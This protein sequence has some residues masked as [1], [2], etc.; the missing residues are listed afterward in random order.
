MA[1]NVSFDGNSLQTAN[2]LTQ[3]IDHASI[4][5][6]DAQMYAIAHANKSVIPFVAYPSKTIKLSGVVLDSSIT[7]LDSRLDTFRA[8][9]LNQDRNLDIDYNGVTRRYTATVNS[10]SINR[11]GGLLYATFEIE[12]VC[13]QPFGQDTSTSSILSASGRTSGSYTDPFT[14]PASQT[15]PWQKPV[16]T[17]TFTALTA[18]GS[19]NVIVGNAGTGQQI[20]INRTWANGDVLVVDTNN[21][22]VTVNGTNVSFTGAFPEFQA[23]A[24]NL[25]YSDTLTTRTF[26]ISVVYTPLYL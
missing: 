18:S 16:W 20:T 23:G 21:K 26:N 19:A 8:Y 22:L 11:P 17:I 4:P 6:K 2:I 10:L 12:F 25:T 5:T 15:A 14:F 1:T 9:F 13:T 24:Q 7:A 3:D